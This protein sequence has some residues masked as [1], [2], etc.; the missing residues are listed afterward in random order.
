M[1]YVSSRHQAEVEF[2]HHKNGNAYRKR[3]YQ[4][5]DYTEEVKPVFKDNRDASYDVSPFGYGA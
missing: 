5:A 3:R 1:W 4:E 2:K